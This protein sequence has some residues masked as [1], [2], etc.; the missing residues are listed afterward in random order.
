MI[1]SFFFFVFLDDLKNQLALQ[2]KQKATNG[3]INLTGYSH[4]KKLIY[5]FENTIHQHHFMQKPTLKT[6][7][8]KALNT[9]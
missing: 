8:C 7:S 9:C 1:S 5:L 4:K 2:R 6:S 3:K